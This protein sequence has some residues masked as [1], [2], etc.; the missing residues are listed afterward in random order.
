MIDIQTYDQLGHADHGWLNARHHFSF[1]NYHNP[2]RI[3]FGSLRVI[4]DDIIQPKA[5][6]DMHPHRN[7]EIITYVRSGAITHKD[8][9]GN[10]GRTIA[11]DVQ[12]MS[13]GR[14]IYH[15]EYNLE[16]QDTSLYQIWIEPNQKNVEPRWDTQSFPQQVNDSELTLLVSGEKDAPLFIHQDVKIY[17]GK[18]NNN[19][20]LN[21]P[22]KDQA[23]VLVSKGEIDIDGQAMHKGDGAQITEQDLINIKALSDAEILVIDVP[24]T[25]I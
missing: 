15:S 9:K 23:Y 24:T 18:L 4:N 11:G 8:N 19:T 20:E 3:S 6:F 25:S 10:Q 2:K 14:G 22:I 13:A 17:A 16:T 21:H 12:V 7:M 5:G 1:A